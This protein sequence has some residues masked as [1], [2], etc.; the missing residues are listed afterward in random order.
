MSRFGSCRTKAARDPVPESCADL[1]CN[2]ASAASRSIPEVAKELADA[3]FKSGV[4]VASYTRQNHGGKHE[5]EDRMMTTK[6]V[7]GEAPL[8]LVGVLDGHDTDVA[9]DTVSRMLPDAVSKHLQS[10]KSVERSYTLA[11]AE[12]EEKLKKVCATAGTCVCCCTIIG[13]HVWC[14]NL[15]DCRAVL[16]PLKVPESASNDLAK[17]ITR[18]C[19]MSRDHKASDP[20]EMRRIKEAG[21]VVVDGRVESLEPSRTLGDF[22]VKL[23][24]KEGVISIVP[25]VRYQAFGEHGEA[26]Q[27]LLVCATDGVWDVLGGADICNCI[28]VRKK[29]LAE[30]QTLA[31]R[32]ES[33]TGH[34]QPLCN[35]AED[36]VTLAIGRGSMDDCTAVAALLSV[37]PP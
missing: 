14:A 32:G 28:Q 8:H 9:S 10:G 20:E 36:F 18:L 13:R 35:L 3:G 12:V 6:G 30:L 33:R 16:I 31:I 19:W 17:P 37:A 29:A 1:V 7:C 24:T 25:E 26:A 34:L 22:D 11:M 15:G 27:A 4:E 5:N 23:Q 21:G 2:H